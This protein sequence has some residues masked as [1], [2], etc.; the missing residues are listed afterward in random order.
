MHSLIREFASLEYFDVACRSLHQNVRKV[1]GEPACGDLVRPE[2]LAQRVD[3]LLPL[4]GE[5]GEG[6][7]RIQ[8]VLNALDPARHDKAEVAQLLQSAG[9]L[10]L[11]QLQIGGKLA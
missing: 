3:L 6:D 5:P 7:S 4:V 11:S 10:L 9:R 2:L 8:R 1:C